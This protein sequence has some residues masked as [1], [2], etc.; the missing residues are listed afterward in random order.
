RRDHGAAAPAGGGGRARL[1]ALQR[2]LQPRPHRRHRLPARVRG[3]VARRG[4][5]PR[6]GPSP[7][8]TVHAG[9]RGALRPP[10]GRRVSTRLVIIRAFEL[11]AV[12]VFAA[13][14]WRVAHDTR[15]TG[16]LTLLGF[17]FVG[18]LAVALV[19]D[20]IANWALTALY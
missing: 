6:E 17:L 19:G 10:G 20:P 12:L 7:V 5:R 4:A 11:E 1:P 9:A 2:R 8:R 13:V 14:A 3:P 18:N 15:A 16:R